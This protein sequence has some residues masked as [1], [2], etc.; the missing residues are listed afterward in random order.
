M[1]L[2]GCVDELPPSQRELLLL[3]YGENQP[4][5]AVAA[6]LGRPVSGVH[7][8]LRT[9]RAKLMECIERAVRKGER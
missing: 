8:S 3:C 4:V 5:A 1:A 2:P 6:K 9:I 7:N